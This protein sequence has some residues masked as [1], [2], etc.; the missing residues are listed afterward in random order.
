MHLSKLLIITSLLLLPELSS[1][2][3]QPLVTI[4]ELEA[5]QNQNILLQAKVQ[6]AQLQKQLDGSDVDSS[7]TVPPDAG[8]L[9][10]SLPSVSGPAQRRPPTELPVILEINGK[11]KR[12]HAVLR[13]ADGRQTRVTTGSS[14]PGIKV[15][16]KSIS[17]S[18]VTL[19]DGTTLT[20]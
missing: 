16:V 20:F 10:S 8:Q 11:D 5:Q 3:T 1:A 18:G 6:G 2:T 9:T 19:S 7:M 15:T 14:I 17:L 12:L 4:G 13:L